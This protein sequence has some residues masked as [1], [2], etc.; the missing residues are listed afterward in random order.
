MRGKVAHFQV[1]PAAVGNIQP[2]F[3]SLAPIP[4]EMQELMAAVAF[5]SI[6]LKE[7]QG[8]H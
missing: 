4:D 5:P 2:H 6:L 1:G 7:N 3:R 8:F